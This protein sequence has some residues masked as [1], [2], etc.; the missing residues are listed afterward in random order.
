MSKPELLTKLL[1][2]INTLKDDLNP[3]SEKIFPEPSNEEWEMRNKLLKEN[4][5][6]PDQFSGSL[7]RMG[8][9]NALYELE[10]QIKKLFK[11]EVK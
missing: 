4:G 1:E 7:C 6:S 10:L 11:K 2:L 3:Y 9:N 8:W 5:L